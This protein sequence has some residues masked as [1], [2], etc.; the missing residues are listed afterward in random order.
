MQTLITDQS[1]NIQGNTIRCSAVV[2]I[3]DDNGVEIAQTAVGTTAALNDPLWPL[4]VVENLRDQGISFAAD[5]GARSAATAVR[6]AYLPPDASLTMDGAINTLMTQVGR[7]IQQILAGIPANSIDLNNLPHG[8]DL[9]HLKRLKEFE[10]RTEGARL[11][12][13]L[14]LPYLPQERNTWPS[15]LAEA[16][17]WLADPEAFTPTLTSIAAGR[18]ITVSELVPLVMGNADLF[19]QAAGEILGK[20][21]RLIQMVW[22]AGAPEEVVV[23]SW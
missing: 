12:E 7:Q 13:E 14:A 6:N 18:S 4:A 20:Q 8:D 19:R 9:D 5:V 11:L 17:A 3:L 10:I 23:I 1:Y 22:S 21:Q 16:E 15:Q 2:K